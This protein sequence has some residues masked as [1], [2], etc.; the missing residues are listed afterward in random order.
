[1]VSGTGTTVT[2]TPATFTIALSA[3]STQS[4]TVQYATADGTAIV[5]SDYTSA[6]GTL[7]FAPGETQKTVTVLVTRDSAAEANET[8]QLKLSSPINAT[9]TKATATG[10]IVDDDTAV[11]PPVVPPVTPPV[12]PPVPSLSVSSG[13]VN[14]GN[15]GTSAL[16]FT[17]SLS[18]ASTQPV[19]VQYST[20]DGT[21][22]AGSD[23]T[24]ATGT[25]TFAAGELTKTIT[26]SVAGD[27]AVETD[28]TLIVK[29]G[30]VLAATIA[31]GTGT[32]TIVND[33]TVLTGSYNYAEVLQ[34]SLLFYDAQR[35]GDLPTAFP[36]N[37]RG[38]SALA[39]GS[40]V[41]LDLSGGY[42]DAGDHVKFGL[43][44]TSS[45]TM[46]GWGVVQ[47]RDAYAASG[48]LP[49]M[50]ESLKWGTDW[51]IKAHPSA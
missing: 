3:A 13:R 37:W 19:S 38:D 32:G 42:Y 31:N 25:L 15:T 44:M 45:M 29:L 49:Q 17:V 41:G 36:L 20:T 21:A 11:T 50:L 48:L 9:L 23:Y 22:T 30:T 8:F 35:S 16:T 33:D 39:D 28:E 27:T 7:T 10:T 46:L 1:M 43:P 2:A 12:T 18:A 40:D 24:A 5:G 51:I 4:I 26:V 6:S 47:Y 14:E 34:K